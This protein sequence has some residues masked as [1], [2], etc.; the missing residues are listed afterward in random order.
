MSYLID[1]LNFIGY[2][3][4]PKL[5]SKKLKDFNKSDLAN[6]LEIDDGNLSHWLKGDNPISKTNLFRICNKLSD[7]YNLKITPEII[8]NQS[9]EK[10]LSDYRPKYNIADPS[11]LI[12]DSFELIEKITF[13][14]RKHT[15]LQSLIYQLL[16]YYDE[17]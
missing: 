3:L 5:K 9:L 17:R 8:M 2:C 14:L 1:N 15:H 6:F 4:F 7:Y 10:Y 13:L 12:K 11:N 16:K